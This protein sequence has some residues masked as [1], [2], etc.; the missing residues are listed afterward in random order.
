MKLRRI[1]LAT[2]AVAGA[3]LLALVLYLAFGDLSRH[4]AS[5]ESLASEALGRPFA[6]DGTFELRVLPSIAVVAERVRIGNAPWGTAPQ[7]VEVGHFSTEIRFWSLLFGPVDVR[8]LELRD[9]SI[10]LE[11][12]AAG[13]GNW[14]PGTSREA[15]AVPDEGLTGIPAVVLQASLTNVA[16]S[17]REAG[18][19]ARTA[20]LD[21]ATIGLGPDG[22]LAVSGRG[23][24]EGRAFALK[25]EAGPVEALFAGKDLRLSVEAAVDRLEARLHGTLGRLDPL[26]GADLTLTV[27]H[28]DLAA[29]LK[30]LDQP[31]F[32]AGELAMT[33]RLSGPGPGA[34]L[35]L[36]ARAGD[37]SLK[38]EGALRT[39][40]LAGASLKFDASVAEAARVAK[41]FGVD[42][43]GAGA[44]TAGARI[45][46]APDGIKLEGASAEFAGA[47]ATAEGTLRASGADLHVDFA[48]RD[49]AVLRAGLPAIPLSLDGTVVADGSRLELKDAKGRLAKS[50]FSLQ[51]AM[52]GGD[53]PH[54]DAELASP[55]LDLN[56]LLERKSGG[57]AEAKPAKQGQGKY[58]FTEAPLP[59]DAL[60]SLDARAH[61]VIGELRIAAG[62]LKDLDA[63]LSAAGGKASLELR[64]RGGVS[65][66]LEGKLGLEPAG[67]GAAHLALD[68]AAK[69]LRLGLGAG[70]EIAPG[71][72]PATSARVRLEA[73]GASARELASGANGRIQVA[74][75]PGKVRSGLTGVVGGDLLG[76]LAGKLNPFAAQDPYTQLD[77]GVIRGEIVDGQAALEPM[78]MQ[79]KKVAVVAGGHVDLHT[80]ALQVDF[81]TRPR[82]GIG[83][84]AGMFA[85]PFIEIAGTLASPRLG[86]G[87]KGAAAGAAAAMT[88]GVTVLAQGLLDRARGEQDLCKDEKSP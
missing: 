33:A 63:T 9:V 2:L 48:A 83:I 54:V 65:G 26:A 5:L 23:A 13:E 47:K 25:G 45:A 6:I 34:R 46:A 10:R 49:L 32:A 70:G 51:F 77:C 17:Y 50:E 44:L 72:V 3:V 78:F 76:E 31:A 52:Q 68:L 7:M 84:S 87:A 88:G 11:R 73:K 1:A 61:V 14:V 64:A 56:P 55:R 81:N 15:P 79:T 86:V 12:N 41:A 75:G 66:R 38:A 19:A 71:D 21:T 58:V 37:L 35:D 85:T 42:G 28:P 22:L 80:E 18:K 20:R 67:G 8:S 4:K 30:G 62:S 57:G 43:L 60:K 82:T 59:L 16:V 29:L 36:D 74:A 27:N 53:T 24:L 39:L 40:G 69:E